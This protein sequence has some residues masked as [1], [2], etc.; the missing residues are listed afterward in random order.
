M[1]TDSLARLAIFSNLEPQKLDVLKQYS[2]IRTYP[3]NTV[4]IHEGDEAS[5][6]Y[7]IESG[8]VDVYLSN[9]NGREIIIN[10]LSAGDTF[11]EL[12]LI[13]DAPRSA[14]VRTTKA[15]KMIVIQK[16]GFNELLSSHPELGVHILK[17]LTKLVRSLSYSIRSLALMDVYGRVARLFLD[18]ADEEEG[19][20][21]IHHKLT[22]QDIANR[23]GA[24]R[25]MVARIMKDLIK[26]GFI[27]Q[28]GGTLIINESLSQ[29]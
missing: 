15:S 2:A 10:E 23:I 14:S 3:K 24:S 9:E 12:A 19:V 22:Q 13:D 25:E 26:G 6:L 4:I 1:N 5:T 29:S 17:Y 28:K 11:G 8:K 27:H 18:L 21:V 7:A 20:L 16:S